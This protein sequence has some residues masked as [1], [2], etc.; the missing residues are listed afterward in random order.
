[1]EPHVALHMWESETGRAGHSSIAYGGEFPAWA[2]DTPG[3]AGPQACRPL[4]ETD[5]QYLPRRYGFARAQSSGARNPALRAAPPV[6]P[7]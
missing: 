6:M 3:P 2:E 7:Y 4:N 5:F 1:M